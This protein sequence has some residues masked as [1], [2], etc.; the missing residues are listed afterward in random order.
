[1]FDGI[2]LQSGLYIF[3]FL[4]NMKKKKIYIAGQQGMVGQSIYKLLKKKLKSVKKLENSRISKIF[5][6]I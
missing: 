5:Q 6:V 3:F 2:N 1:M 4:I